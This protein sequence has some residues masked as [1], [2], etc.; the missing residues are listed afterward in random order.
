V[1]QGDGTSLDAG[2]SP[3]LDAFV[4]RV[5][6]LTDADRRAIA[7]ARKAVD[8]SFHQSALLAASELLVGRADDY[9]RARSALATAHV[10][11]ALEDAGRDEVDDLNEVARY[12]QLAIDD[13]LLAVLTRDALHPNHLREL[14]RS[15][16][17]VLGASPQR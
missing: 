6:S 16:K 4:T 7:D 9:A 5:L 15:L 2:L 13:G 3:A 11:Q 10:P 17:V 8:E 1:G 14:H 12:V